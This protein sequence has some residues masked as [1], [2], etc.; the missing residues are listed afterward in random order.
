MGSRQSA[1]PDSERERESFKKA[2]YMQGRLHNVGLLMM[3]FVCCHL[4]NVIFALMCRLAASSHSANSWE[5][6]RAEY[7]KERKRQKRGNAIKISIIRK[8]D[9]LFFSR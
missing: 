5:R 7:R 6:T 3:L 9:R 1:N 8:L 4:F 2:T